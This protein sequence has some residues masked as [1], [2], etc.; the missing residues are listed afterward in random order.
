MKDKTSTE[1]KNTRGKEDRKAKDSHMSRVNV[2]LQRLEILKKSSFP[3]LGK[4]GANS[5]EG[6]LESALGCH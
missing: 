2:Q 4:L 1:G 5:S 6:Q 3:S